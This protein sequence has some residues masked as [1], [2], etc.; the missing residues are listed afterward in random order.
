MTK[1]SAVLDQLAYMRTYAPRFPDEDRTDTVAEFERLK[2]QIA[3]LPKSTAN[4]EWFKLSQI[5]I[6]QAEAAYASGDNERGDRLLFD[7]SEHLRQAI[8]G[9]PVRP[10]YIVTPDGEVEPQ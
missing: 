6:G 8:S 5:E 7:A 1:S 10:H 9:K 2:T 4:S 3:S